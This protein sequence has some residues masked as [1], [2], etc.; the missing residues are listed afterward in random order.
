MHVLRIVQDN[1]SCTLITPDIS[2]L[3]QNKD[4]DITEGRS[5][6]ETEVH[7]QEKYNCSWN[8][9]D[10][11]CEDEE[12]LRKHIQN[13]KDHMALIECEHCDE[14]FSRSKQL[15]RHMISVHDAR[16][17]KELNCNDCDFQGNNEAQLAKHLH[18]TQHAP[19]PRI[20]TKVR[21]V[22]IQCF[23]CDKQFS[24]K[25][26]LMEHRKIDHPSNKICR[27]YKKGSCKRN[28]EDC[29][30]VHKTGDPEVDGTDNTGHKCYI[31]GNSF[32]NKYDMMSHKKTTHPSSTP[33][34]K[35]EN[36]KCSRVRK[37]AGTNTRMTV[38]K[39]L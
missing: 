12:M 33:C 9:C 6:S 2:D 22:T 39:T 28:N 5:Q 32:T 26:N 34:T 18:E 10:Q 36:G 35:Y 21:L 24:S 31:C 7:I 15:Q 16:T 17:D 8:D 29:W 14:E 27:D 23:T 3:I 1:N 25:W 37:N 30:Y 13:H 19:S 11:T 20:S 38:I 4:S